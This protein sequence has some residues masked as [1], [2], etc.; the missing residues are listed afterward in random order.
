M[1]EPPTGRTR[2]VHPYQWL[3]EPLEEEPTFLLRPMFG[4]KSVYLDGKLMLYFTAKEEPWRGVLACTDRAHHASLRAEFPAL[5]P[6]P[7]LPK[8]L[9][10]PES[11]DS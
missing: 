1:R 8:W 11:A 10:L 3:W 9:Y 7:V 6:H 2:K 4:G 5:A